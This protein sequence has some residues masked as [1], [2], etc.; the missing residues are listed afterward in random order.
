M[1]LNLLKR[2]ND[3][4]LNDSVDFATCHIV[5]DY[6]PCTEINNASL[7]FWQNEWSD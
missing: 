3:A 6:K 7:F 2:S 4:L 5:I 1:I